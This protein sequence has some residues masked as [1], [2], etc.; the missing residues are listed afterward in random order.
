MFSDELC[1]RDINA[2]V[3]FTACQFPIIRLDVSEIEFL[4]TALSPTF[5]NGPLLKYLF[6]D[7]EMRRTVLLSFFRSIARSGQ[8][9]GEIYVTERNE[10]GAVWIS[11]GDTLPLECL[12]QTGIF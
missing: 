7:E 9:S 3:S 4:A 5:Y 10:D 8:V 11:R 6:P 2:S 1:G 12:V